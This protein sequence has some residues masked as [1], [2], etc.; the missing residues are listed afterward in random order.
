[1]NMIFPL[2][3]LLVVYLFLSASLPRLSVWLKRRRERCDWMVLD[4]AV[5]NQMSRRMA[6]QDRDAYELAEELA[7]EIEL[8][9]DRREVGE[10]VS[11]VVEIQQLMDMAEEDLDAR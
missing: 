6:D 9:V 10:G 8:A 2:L 1:M 4:D 11:R 7:A 5:I 3:T